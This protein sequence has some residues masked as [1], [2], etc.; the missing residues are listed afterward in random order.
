MYTG[1]APREFGL[2][3]NASS[4]KSYRILT[5]IFLCLIFNEISDMAILDL[6]ESKIW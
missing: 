5:E 3:A 2:Q 1:C 4:G 6:A